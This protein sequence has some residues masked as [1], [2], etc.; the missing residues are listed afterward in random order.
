MG[1]HLLVLL[2]G[3]RHQF[4]AKRKWLIGL[5]QALNESVIDTSEVVFQ[6]WNGGV[7]HGLQD[8][9]S[10]FRGDATSKDMARHLEWVFGGVEKAEE[11]DN[12]PRFIAKRLDE[13]LGGLVL[14]H[15]RSDLADIVG[16]ML[17]KSE[18]L[19]CGVQNLLFKEFVD[20]AVLSNVAAEPKIGGE[21]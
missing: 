7:H 11:R 3:N 13:S 18:V 19:P 12:S 1:L 9:R 14:F 16:L 2:V 4:F 10:L 8:D 15:Q 21:V 17:Q 20:D 6:A 5:E